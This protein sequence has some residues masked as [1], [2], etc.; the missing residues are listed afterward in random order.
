MRVLVIGAT[1]T[2]GRGVVDGLVAA[3]EDVRA[4][5]RRPGEVA[6]P[7]GVE[8][9]AGDL[10]DPDSVTAA[11]EGVD[12]LYL[13]ATGETAAV[14]GKARAAG[15]TRAVLL[16]SAA[17]GHGGEFEGG[18][19]AAAEAAVEGSGLE[20][21][22]LRPGMFA[23]NLLGWAPLIRAEGVV[24]EPV[25]AAAQAPIHELDIAEVAVAALRTDRH[26]GQVLTLSGPETLTKVQQAETI[27]AAIGRE[28][29][30]EELSP[31]EW[32]SVWVA[33]MPSYLAGVADWLLGIWARSAATPDTP[34]TTVAEVLGKPARTLAQWAADHAEDFR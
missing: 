5:T 27:G 16:S 1:G 32:K 7:A 28:I 25:A 18:S 11:V 8:V 33:Q 30:F 34:S 2:V 23:S 24:R 6:F 4:M 29:R 9:V 17:V 14:L 26:V 20:W 10:T 19:H 3:G 13:L 22:H 12:R 31:E 15:A 21:T